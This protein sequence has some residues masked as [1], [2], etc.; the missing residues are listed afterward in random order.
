[1][2]RT[3][4]TSGTQGRPAETGGTPSVRWVCSG[5]R[6]TLKAPSSQSGQHVT[7]P[8][9][10]AL[11]QIPADLTSRPPGHAAGHSG[12]DKQQLLRR[13]AVGSAIFLVVWIV[14]LLT[15][16]HFRNQ[17]KANAER[18]R[19]EA[20]TRI[21]TKI[22]KAKGLIQVESYQE[23]KKELEEALAAAGN[24]PVFSEH[25]ANIRSMMEGDEIQYGGQGMVKIGRSWYAREDVPKAKERQKEADRQIGEICDTVLTAIKDGDVVRTRDKAKAALDLMD[26]WFGE[27]HPRHKDVLDVYN[28]AK[29]EIEAT[30]KGL[31]RYKDSWVTPDRKF[32]LEQQDKGLVKYKGKWMTPDEKFE[33]EQID[34]GMVKYNGKW[35]TQDEKWTAEGYVKFEGKWVKPEERDR[36]LAQRREE[37]ERRAREEAQRRAEAERR[38]QAEAK[39]RAAESKKV[40]AYL[41]SQEFIKKQLKAP[42]SARFPAFSDSAV[43]VTYD[44][45]EEKYNVMAWVEGQNA[46]GVY[47][48]HNYMCVLWPAGGDLW[49]CSLA[50]ILE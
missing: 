3:T 33:Q 17:A 21:E 24:D 47:L 36:V 2:T 39:R 31:V 10:G 50:T 11:E 42:S 23:A 12:A 37:Q 14:V 13:L 32:D 7:C 34:K 43:I 16:L 19:A 26:K 27:K 46:F 22:E 30:A 15:Y 6:A 45:K 25:V 48:R 41:M 40:D 29:E 28:Y 9:C 5:C 20:R 38:A 8:K 18:A 4:N 49:R 1:M 35:V 44:E